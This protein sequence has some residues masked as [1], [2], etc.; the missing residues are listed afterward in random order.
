[1]EFDYGGRQIYAALSWPQAMVVLTTRYETLGTFILAKH[2]SLASGAIQ[3]IGI[4]HISDE[5]AYA[6]DTG[7]I[8]IN[9]GF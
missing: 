3:R 5:A 7:E 9:L 8:K 6:T 4:N 2:A 1:M